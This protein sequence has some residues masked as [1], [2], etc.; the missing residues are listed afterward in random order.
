[1]LTSV[2]EIN[3]EQSSSAEDGHTNK[4]IKQQYIFTK[5]YSFLSLY[6]PM[7]KDKAHKFEERERDGKIRVYGRNKLPHAML[8][9]F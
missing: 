9:Y 8:L 2:T 7:L 6:F 4:R 3:Q 5:L 1:M